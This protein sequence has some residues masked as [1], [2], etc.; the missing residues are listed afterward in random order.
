[1]TPS[2]ASTRAIAA[3]S[4]TTTITP[5]RGWLDWRL[6][7]LW[8]YR[9][10]VDLFVWRDFV[11]VYKQT[12]LGPTW[13]IIRP[14]FTTL[15]FTLVFGQIARLSTDGA[16]PFLFY[17]VGNVAWTY[18][19]NCLDNTSKTFLANAPLF[20]KVYF[21]RLVI[22]IALVLSNLIAFAIQFAILVVAMLIYEWS[23]TRLHPTETLFLFPFLMAVLV[24]YSFAG[25]LTVSALTTKY[26]DLSYLVTFGI[27]LLMYLTPVIYPL[28]AVPHQ[29]RWVAAINPLTPVFEGLRLGLLGAGTMTFNQLGVSVLVLLIALL[30]GLVLF[31]RAERTFMDTV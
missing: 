25:G 26:R 4:L 11:A 30:A 14:L 19:S 10:L 2:A 3:A 21:H 27:Q 8:R 28:S 22:P 23:G 16:P 13:H 7:Q 1:M 31:T 24:G 9:D 20:G 15:T 18:F 17:M 12:I 6:P 29:F 5:Q